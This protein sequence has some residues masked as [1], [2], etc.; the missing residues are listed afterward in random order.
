M[1]AAADNIIDGATLRLLGGAIRKS[2]RSLHVLRAIDETISA[3]GFHKRRADNYLTEA[4]RAYDV[5]N[6]PNFKQVFANEDR[7]CHALEAAQD[8]TAVVI[9]EYEVKLKAARCDKALAHDDGVCEAFEEALESFVA[10]NNLLED[11]RWA[12]MEH[13]ADMENHVVNE[14][15]LCRTSSD[16]DAMLASIRS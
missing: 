4:Q 12:V 16:I 5:I 15:K 6:S 14:A 9:A 3:L 8:S 10:L 11:L 1:N 2:A 7:I 13:S